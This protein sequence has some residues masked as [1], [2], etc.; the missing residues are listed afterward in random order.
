MTLGL[1][2][3][4]NRRRRRFWLGVVKWSIVL[5]AILAAGVYAYRTGSK[6]AEHDVT[7]LREEVDELTV[8]VDSLTS[9]N[10]ALEHELAAAKQEAQ[11]WQTRYEREVPTGEIKRLTDMVG[12]K[13]RDGVALDRLAFLIE[14][15]DDIAACD[16][17]P[18]TK[19]FIVPTPLYDGPNSWVGFADSSIT[20]TARGE[21]AVND[22]GQPEG[23][24][25]PAKPVT[26]MFTRLG[27]GT[28]EVTGELPLH[29]SML[30]GDSEYRFTVVAGDRGFLNV[31]AD[32]CKAP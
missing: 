8:T 25:D 24:F 2:D 1:R 31:T 14:A 19:R 20:V 17:Q 3:S 22:N 10:E 26:L 29:H 6:L 27:G 21:S 4:R 18:A 15:S 9:E 12:Q 13:V 11:E 23:W 7:E 28:S 16:N 30:V 32:R 5:I